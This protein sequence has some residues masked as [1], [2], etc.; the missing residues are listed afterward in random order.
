MAPDLKQK[1]TNFTEN[2]LASSTVT[3]LSWDECVFALGL[4][5]ATFAS[6][7]ARTTDGDVDKAYEHAKKMFSLGMAAL[8]HDDPPKH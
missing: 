3:G 8:E 4:T 1:I 2:I 6:M 5:T 7:A